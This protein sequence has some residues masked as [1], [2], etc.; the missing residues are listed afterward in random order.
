MVSSAR[1]GRPLLVTILG[2]LLL[3]LAAWYVVLACEA[4]LLFAGDFLFGGP[5][6][7]PSDVRFGPLI[8]V[9]SAIGAVIWGFVTSGGL[10]SGAGWARVS[11][12][13]LS[14]FALPVGFPS[15]LAAAAVVVLVLFVPSNARA[16]FR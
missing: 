3:A 12:V 8:M 6:P 9:V 16:Y 11:T 2:L 14:L 1:P 5:A 13:L 10:F 15:D 4:V 7:I